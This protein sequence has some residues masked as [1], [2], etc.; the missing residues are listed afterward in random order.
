[1]IPFSV[2]LTLI[3]SCELL[4]LPSLPFRPSQS[5]PS[6]LFES[7]EEPGDCLIWGG[8]QGGKFQQGRL[9]GC[10]PAVQ[11]GIPSANNLVPAN[12]VDS[13]WLHGESPVADWLQHQLLLV[14]ILAQPYRRHRQ[15]RIRQ[16]MQIERQL[17]ERH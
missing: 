3:K 1:M 12:F 15:R 9:P 13:Q 7:D 5:H 16:K 10:Q 6:L 4:D 2:F 11:S 8:V 17:V 14:L